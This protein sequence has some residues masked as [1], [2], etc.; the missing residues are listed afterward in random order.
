MRIL[1]LTYYQIQKAK[2][3]SALSLHFYDTKTI[4][5][6]IARIKQGGALQHFQS[7]QSRTTRVLPTIQ[8]NGWDL[9]RYAILA[10]NRHYVPEITSSALDAAILR[11]PA[12]GKL[13][14]TDGNHGIG[15]QI[16]HFAEAAVVSPVFYWMWGSV[17]SNVTQMRAD[18]GE[19]SSFTTGVSEVVGCVWEMEIVNFEIQA[20]KET[21]LSESG[22]ASEKLSRYLECHLP[23][24]GAG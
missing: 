18:W 17:L 1:I 2:K 22:S 4:C 8:T 14:D 12:A 6:R 19:P 5:L 3:Q 15:F 20:W 16:V 21:M 13:G 24:T 7:Y 11:L 9:K 23:A 10:K